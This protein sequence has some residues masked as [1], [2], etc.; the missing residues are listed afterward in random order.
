[1]GAE[2]VLAMKLAILLCAAAAAAPARDVYFDGANV[3]HPAFG[4]EYRVHDHRV[5]LIRGAVVFRLVNSGAP[6]V[7]IM[8]P[9]VTIQPY[10]TGD[11]RIEVNR[12]GET[13]IVPYGGDLRVIAPSGSQWLVVGQKMIARGSPND[14]EFRIVNA[15]T[16]WTRLADRI[17]QA[18]R[19]GG[20]SG[21]AAFES[22][23]SDDNEG[24]RSKPVAAK[25]DPTPRNAPPKPTEGSPK[26]AS[27][28][29]RGK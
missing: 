17:A 16:P 29:P 14:P 23:A 12:F 10:F 9:S 11:Y 4:A 22:G 5:E 27:G 21:G 15:V 28:T 2:R 26:T 1:M 7:E 8:T 18:V 13:V 3:L 6:P 24:A 20:A 19:S 25:P